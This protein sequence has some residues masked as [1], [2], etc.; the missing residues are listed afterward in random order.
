MNYK[1][2]SRTWKNYSQWEISTIRWK[3]YKPTRYFRIIVGKCFVASVSVRSHISRYTFTIR[4]VF[5]YY[6]LFS[7]IEI[8][9]VSSYW[10]STA[11]II[12]KRCIASLIV[13]FREEE[14]KNYCAY[15]CYCWQSQCVKFFYTRTVRYQ[16][17]YSVMKK[18]LYALVRFVPVSRPKLVLIS[19]I[20]KGRNVRIT[21]MYRVTHRVQAWAGFFHENW[22]R[23][24][25]GWRDG[26]FKLHSRSGKAAQNSGSADVKYINNWRVANAFS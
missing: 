4:R 1:T 21:Q 25:C 6:I 26:K 16:H 8:E 17:Q 7:R 18:T 15:L 13:R 24:P 14:R 22:C 3:V 5:S 19:C 23:I 9:P 11:S 2:S 12:F 10:Y 20:R